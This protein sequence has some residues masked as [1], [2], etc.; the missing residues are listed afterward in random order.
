MRVLEWSP[1]RASAKKQRPDEFPAAPD[2][3]PRN[4]A[5]LAATDFGCGRGVTVESPAVAGS[6]IFRE[7]EITTSVMNPIC[8]RIE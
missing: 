7:A 2:N 6:V 3:L 5:G 1:A 4:P 8:P